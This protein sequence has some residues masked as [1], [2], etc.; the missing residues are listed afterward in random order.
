MHASNVKAPPHLK[1][2]LLT[3]SCRLVAT[4]LLISLSCVCCRKSPVSSS[5]PL[6]LNKAPYTDE[7][8]IIVVADDNYTGWSK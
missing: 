6:C 7:N 3:T 5:A 4:A 1:A 8:I 2:C